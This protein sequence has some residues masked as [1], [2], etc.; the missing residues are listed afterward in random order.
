MTNETQ[1]PELQAYE[2][3][4]LVDD[5]VASGKFDAYVYE[6]KQGNRTVKG[7]SAAAFAHLGLERGISITSFEFEKLEDG[8]LCTAEA[9]R[10]IV[11]P[12]ETIVD[13]DGAETTKAEVIEEITAPGA[14]F[15]PYIAYGKPDPF[16]WQKALTKACRNARRD[17]IPAVEQEQ[18]VEQLLKLS[19]AAP[20]PTAR[21]APPANHAPPSAAPLNGN[22]HEDNENARKAAFATYNEKAET[23]DELGITKNLFWAGVKAHF[24]VTS[25]SEM[26]TVQYQ[27]LRKSLNAKGFAR[28]I[29]DLAPKAPQTEAA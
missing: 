21:P 27:E 13:A 1:T 22:H 9:T 25:R 2:I 20:A 3:Q 11:T 7:L 8:V 26:T 19:A 5:L 29:R 14:N 10:R 18:A 17:L 16:C 15:A 23:L 4:D 28:W 12:A 6:Y 24:K